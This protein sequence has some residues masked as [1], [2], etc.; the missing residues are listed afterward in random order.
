M[1]KYDNNVEIKVNAH[2][3][4]LEQPSSGTL[5]MKDWKDK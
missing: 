1:P 2:N 3:E 5:K 4:F